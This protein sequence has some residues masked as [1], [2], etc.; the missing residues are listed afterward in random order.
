MLSKRTNLYWTWL[1]YF[2]IYTPTV[3][4]KN[5]SSQRVVTRC[6]LVDRL[7][8][9]NVPPR[10]GMLRF[11][12]LNIKYKVIFST[13]CKLMDISQWHAVPQVERCACFHNVIW[14]KILRMNSVIQGCPEWKGYSQGCPESK[15]F[16]NP[17]SNLCLRCYSHSILMICTL[18]NALFFTQ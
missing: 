1:I 9:V 13:E 16:E 15:K 8:L 3:V 11:K 10:I 6:E 4:T 18:Y 7:F 14:Y 12:W 5:T 2:S 17:W